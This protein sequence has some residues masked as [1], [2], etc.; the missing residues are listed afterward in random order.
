MG[1]SVGGSSQAGSDVVTSNAVILHHLSNMRI[2][3]DD[4]RELAGE[5]FPEVSAVI[6][7]R[8]TDATKNFHLA[9]A[10]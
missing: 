4:L 5:V 9:P 1:N 6:L 3:L 10:Q 2:F 8:R 7:Q